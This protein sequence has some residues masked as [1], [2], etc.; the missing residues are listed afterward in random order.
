MKYYLIGEEQGESLEW[1]CPEC[2][3]CGGLCQCKKGG[4]P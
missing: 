1:F 3:F 4:Q 2:G